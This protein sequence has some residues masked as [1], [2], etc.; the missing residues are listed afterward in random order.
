MGDGGE[1]AYE[2]QAHVKMARQNGGGGPSSMAEIVLIRTQM[3]DPWVENSRTEVAL[4][5]RSVAQRATETPGRGRGH[6]RVA[7]H[8]TVMPT[9]MPPAT[10]AAIAAAAEAPATER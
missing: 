5:E 2:G 1:G 9:V 10:S 8:P 4:R 7:A 3:R 6:W